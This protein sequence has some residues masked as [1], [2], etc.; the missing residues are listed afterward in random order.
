MLCSRSRLLMLAAFCLAS[1]ARPGAAHHETPERC[2]LTIE[3]TDAATGRPLPGLIQIRGQD[4]ARIVARELIPRGLGVGESYAIHDWQLLPAAKPITVP[5]QRLVIR[6]FQ[7]LET[8]FGEATVDLREQKSAAVKIPLKRFFDA[9]DRGWQS[10][11]THVHLQKVGREESEKYL[12]QVAAAEQLDLIYISYLER[13]EADLQYTTNKYTADD[14]KRLTELSRAAHSHPHVHGSEFDNGQ[15][16][17]HNFAGFGEGYGHVMFLHLQRLVRPVSIGPGIMKT[18]VDSPALR[19]GIEQAR[20]QGAAVIWCHNQWGLEDVPSWVGGRLHANNIFDGGTHGSYRH[21]FYRYL[22]AGLHVPFSTGTDWFVYDFSRVYVRGRP[23]E[24]D[25][26]SRLSS[27]QW[28][29]RLS[30]GRSVITN[31][32]LVQLVVE[33][34]G[35]G[36]T[37]RLD[38]PREVLVTARGSGRLDFQHLELVVNGEVVERAETEQ[39][40][41]HVRAAIDRRLAVDG[42][43][44]IAVRTPPPST[45]RD[46]DLQRKTPLNEYGRELFAHTS[47]AYVEVKGRGVFQPA[48]AR[49]LVAEMEQSLKEIDQHA[50][51][52]NEKQ[53]RDVHRQYEEAIAE[54]RRRLAGETE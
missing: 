52:Q 29:K 10:A 28:L 3:L 6:A 44:W 21:S 48:A 22:N 42:P 20:Q 8:E 43:C 17:R 37:V 18:G 35:P 9:R 33:G 7:G 31:G 36:D 46:A 25:S 19:P 26:D 38:G 2:Q 45:K 14:L 15:E 4:G 54:L 16:H 1:L 51:F 40:G 50:T 47:P 30:E 24:V 49:D 41:G 12:L 13:A 5:R 32:P 27:A 34:Q 11:N 39:N 23:G 53:R